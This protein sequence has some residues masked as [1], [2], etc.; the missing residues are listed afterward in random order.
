MHLSKLAITGIFVLVA[1]HCWAAEDS[2]IDLKFDLIQENIEVKGPT[3]AGGAPIAAQ[4]PVQRTSNCAVVIKA[5]N[6]VRRNKDTLGTT[7]RDNSIISKPAVTD[8]L[9]DALLDMKKEGLNTSL[10]T[11][12]DL[13]PSPAATYLAA[14][15]EKVYVWFHGMNI[16]GTLVVNTKTQTGSGPEVQHH[17]RVISSK[18]NW[19]NTD[20]EYVTTLNMAASRLIK[21]IATDIE[22]QCAAKV[23]I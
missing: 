14:D 20:S 9:Q 21:Q 5:P 22:K 10:A 1:N 16:N 2:L 23:D 19:A 8:W 18:S 7:F 13:T 11:S 12:A 4:K 6:D 17:Y 15:L 3:A